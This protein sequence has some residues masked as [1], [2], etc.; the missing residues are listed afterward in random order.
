MGITALD[1]YWVT[2]L[3]G[4]RNA[5]HMLTVFIGLVGGVGLMFYGVSG[6]ELKVAGRFAAWL[7][8][9]AAA[10]LMVQAFIP[11]TRSAAAMVVL[12][13][14]INSEAVQTLPAEITTLAKEWLQELRPT[15][16]EEP[17]GY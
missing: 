17:H 4:I 8:P 9:L 15:K 1:V 12:P 10:M 5:L 7:L 14:I 3:D 2:A 16:K 6:G 11:S 13:A